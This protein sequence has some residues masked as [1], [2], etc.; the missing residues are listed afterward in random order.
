MSSLS[1]IGTE[2]RDG[3][4]SDEQV[5]TNLLAW[6]A[7]LRSGKFS[8]CKSVLHQDG[9]GHCC[10][11]VAYEVGGGTWTEEEQPSLADG[12]VCGRVPKGNEGNYELLCGEQLDRVGLDAEDAETL[13]EKNDN[14]SDFTEI[15]DYIEREI[16]PRYELPASA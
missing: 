10:L 5:V 3:V 2:E 12:A 9:V 11:G 1:E 13:A 8:Q 6:I 14:G 4:V 16:L 7:A 15:A